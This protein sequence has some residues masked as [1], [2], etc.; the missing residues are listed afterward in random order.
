MCI[1]DRQNLATNLAAFGLDTL[2]IPVSQDG[3][4]LTLPDQHSLDVVAVSYTHLDVYKRQHIDTAHDS[5]R[6]LKEPVG[7]SPSSFTH[8]DS[9]PICD[10][11]RRVRSSGVQPSPSDTI[12]A[13]DGGSTGA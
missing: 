9:A 5:P 4:V 2:G 1:R 12:D 3:N 10:P 6:A 7:F 8:S 11:S 13:S